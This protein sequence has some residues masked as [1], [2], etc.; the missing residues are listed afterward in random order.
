[1]EIMMKIKVK[2][3]NKFLEKKTKKIRNNINS[4]IGEKDYKIIMDL[5]SKA[6]NKDNL[7]A[8]IKKYAD[9]KYSKKKKEKL[10]EL[11]LSLASIDS[12]IKKIKIIE[13]SMPNKL[14]NNIL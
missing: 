10:M 7:Y 4:L 14:F 9:N 1:M 11:Y 3:G 13:K 5:Y 8:E 12:K 6:K 2:R